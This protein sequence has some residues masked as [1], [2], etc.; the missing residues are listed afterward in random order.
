MRFGISC[1]VPLLVFGSVISA[2][3]QTSLRVE[4]VSASDRRPIA[5]AAVTAGSSAALTDPQGVVVLA[6]DPGVVLLKV[7]HEG[8]RP[9]EREVTVAPGAV[10]AVLVE[11]V[12]EIRM[13][14]EVTVV[15]TTRTGR[16]LEDQPTRVEV[17]EREEI[18]EKMLMTPGD[19]VMMLNEMGG[20]RVQAT[21]PA[22]GAASVRI[23]G[24]LGRYTRLLSDGLPLHGAD[25]AGLTLLQ[26]PP[27]DLGRVE[28][29]KGVASA[30]YGAGAL[31]GVVNLIS[32]QPGAAREVELLLNASTLGASDAVAWIAA[33]ITPR[34]SFSVIAGAHGQRRAD[35]DDDRWADVPRYARGLVRPRVYWNSGTG[36]S[37]LAT[38]GVTREARVGG[39]M[40]GGV[41]AASG[42]PYE[43]ATETTRGDVGVS[44]QSIVRERYVVTARG[45]F[46][47]Q[48]HDATFGERRE[49]DVHRSALAELAVRGATGAHTWVAGVAIDH[50]AY[51]PADV[52]RFQYSFTAPGVF[53]QDDVALGPSVSVSAGV[54]VDRHNVYGTFVSPRLSALVRHGGW[55]SRMSL[56]QGFVASSPLTEETEAAGLSTLA[57]V[58]PLRA[59]RGRSASVDVTRTVGAATVTVTGFAS[60]VRDP[61]SVRRSDAYELRNLD[62]PSTAHGV[63]ALGTF[64]ASAFALTATYTFVRTRQGEGALRAEEPLTPRHSAG[65]VAMVESESQGRAGLEVYVTGSQ[66]LEDNPFRDRSERYVI[67]GF[68]V[69]RPVGKVRVFVN[70]ENVTNV[71]QRKWDPIVRPSRAR[72]GRWTVD[73]WAPLDGR[74]FNAGI[75]WMF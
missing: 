65:V 12:A 75:R 74:V 7:A 4:V 47:R 50:A 36:A 8:R 26:V 51:R 60:R 55:T 48:A 11:L 42:T 3:A 28:V 61:L 64:R 14:E 34:A 69:E 22:L 57:V 16:R 19:V 18:E 13:E 67:V 72:D 56:G 2:A 59:E 6:A 43:E 41:L 15:A 27:M 32:R 52:P 71:R 45:A 20:M 54:R 53:V 31:G 1:A 58:E 44:L 37:A 21:S 25:A 73:A 46:A 38:A 40:P 24:M 63:E 33:P 5:G 10:T 9:V 29:I 35:V 70:A 17:L 49:R 66:A 30:L 68:L 62:R 23:Q 39:T